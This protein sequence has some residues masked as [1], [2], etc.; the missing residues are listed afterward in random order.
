MERWTRLYDYV[1]EYQEL[2]YNYYS[3]HAVAFLTNYYNINSTQ[4]VWD[5][6][7]L[8]G[9]F[10]ERIGTL[11]GVKYNKYLLLPVYFIDEISTSFDGQDIGQVKQNESHIVIPS[12]YNI[13]PIPGDLVKLDQSYL[14]PTNNTYPTFV[15]S[16]VEIHPNTDRRF[17]KLRIE[18]NQSILSTQID[19]QVSDIFVF[20][21]YD[22]N[23]Y[24]LQDA[25]DLA[26]LLSRNEEL[27]KRVKLL[28]DENSGFYTV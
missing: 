2:V 13:T 5:N 15:V 27:S 9:G 1:A 7:E 26:T 23:I 12:T 21:D 20:F 14:R 22:K 18:T 25:T 8:L 6:K 19:Q 4:T 17:W 3:K 10:Y 28:W 11:S 24:P 16:G